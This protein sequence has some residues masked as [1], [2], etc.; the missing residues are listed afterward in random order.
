M[1]SFP[2]L[3]LAKGN[4]HFNYSPAA[5]Q[6]YEF[7]LSFRF[8][9][10]IATLDK[11]RTNDPYN[12][13]VHHIENYIDLFV[14]YTGEGGKSL[15]E[16]KTDRSYRLSQVKLG[17]QQSPY[18]L[19]VQSEIRLHSALIRWK[20]ADY[21]GAFQDITKAYR[22]LKRNQKLFPRFLANQKDLGLIHT[23]IGTIPSNYK[24]GVKLISGLDGT[25]DQ[26][27][28]E[29]R[30]VLDFA[31]EKDFVFK[32]ETQILYALLMLYIQN[33]KE[34][35]WQLLQEFDLRPKESSLHCYIMANVAMLT[36]KNDLAIQ[37]L[38][39]KPT[40]GKF[41]AFNQLE[42]MEGLARLRHLEP[43]SELNFKRF[44][45][46]YK[47]K[48]LI[49]S[50]LQKLA[51]LEVVKGNKAAYSKLIK[52]CLKKGTAETEEDKQAVTEAESGMMPHSK[53]LKARLLYD[54]GYFQEA[55]KVIRSINGR[56][57]NNQRERLEWTYRRGRISQGLKHNMQA[58]ESYMKT[59]ESGAD[60]PYYYACNAALQVGLIYEQ[61]GN[62]EKAR[63]H[64][65]LCL[66]I[67]PREY[68]TS[69]HHQ[70]KSGLKRLKEKKR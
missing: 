49:K 39:N 13:V 8:D 62:V 50:A 17:D 15:R 47:G 48:I 61:L 43:G 32:Q 9:E 69:L 22:L 57:L 45:A 37:L 21:L 66:D 28:R 4:F 70:A 30:A 33:E 31:E 63:K 64:F 5:K 65:N 11:L 29:I 54:G 10:A 46:N 35:A 14:I 56:Q 6:A 58:I 2:A 20:Y 1:I 51:W 67:K 34:A 25:I 59:I 60:Q 12:L 19:Y 40:G 53:L 55:N 16:F 18:Y 7:V 26:G 24:W 38:N 44:L 41:F 68:K 52:E 3:I 36:G 23:I 42:Y 27:M